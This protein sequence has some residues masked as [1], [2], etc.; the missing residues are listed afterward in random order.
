MKVAYNIIRLRSS[1]M[2]IIII[3]VANIQLAN[4]RILGNK[5]FLQCC[6]V[7]ALWFGDYRVSEVLAYGPLL[8]VHAFWC[9]LRF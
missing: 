5:Y 8:H 9:A 2:L 7:V 6:I 4:L 1:L 3:M